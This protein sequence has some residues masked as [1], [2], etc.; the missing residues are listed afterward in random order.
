MNSDLPVCSLLFIIPYGLPF[1]FFP[2]VFHEKNGCLHLAYRYWAMCL[3][4]AIVSFRKS[5][6]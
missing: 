5:D 3:I 6:T 4:H 1:L 2:L